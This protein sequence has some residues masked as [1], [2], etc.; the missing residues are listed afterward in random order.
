MDNPTEIDDFGVPKK[1]GNIHMATAAERLVR[2]PKFALQHVKDASHV[3]VVLH[4]SGRS[5]GCMG[6][7]D[8]G[9]AISLLHHVLQ[10]ASPTGDLPKI[11]QAK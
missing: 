8:K 6:S 7:K 2:K 3:C 9:I 4:N 11:W 10:Q 1:S 5:S